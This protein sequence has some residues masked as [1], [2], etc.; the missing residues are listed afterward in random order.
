MFIYK[1]KYDLF[2]NEALRQETKV[3]SV[4]VFDTLLLREVKPEYIRFQDIAKIQLSQLRT[5]GFAGHINHIDLMILRILAAK[6]AYRNIMPVSGVREAKYSDFMKVMLKSLNC[7]LELIDDLKKIEIDYERTVLYKNNYLIKILEDL[8][9]QGTRIICISDMYLSS[10]D[11]RAL[12][13]AH[14]SIKLFDEIYSSADFGYNKASGLLYH[15]I[16]EIEK[17]KTSEIVHCG[18]NYHSDC[19]MA[20]N[21]GLR[22][23]H[24]PR[25]RVWNVVKRFL[26][27]KFEMQYG[28]I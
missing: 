25:S 2:K 5:L 1:K 7:P 12:I 10:Y 26:Q 14:I 27:R 23:I 28:V 3:V 15:K 21:N 8:K 24:V 4:D 13:G 6:A 20:N 19:F 22:A 16:A 18:D 17:V 9:K 11:I